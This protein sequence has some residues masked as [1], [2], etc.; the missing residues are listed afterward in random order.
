VARPVALVLRALGLGDLLTGVPALR[1]LRRALPDH[2]LLLVEPFAL[3]PLTRLAVA[4]DEVVA[5]RELDPI[6]SELPPV[7]LAVDLHGRGP[8]SM[9][10][11][12]VHEPGELWSFRHPHVPESEGGPTWTADEHEVARWCRMCR[13]FGV[14]ASE[15][16]LSVAVPPPP[17]H[18]RR[19]VVVHPGASA[20]A[21]EWPPERYAAVCQ[22]LAGAYPIVVTGS[23]SERALAQRVVDAA[24]LGASA[25]LAGR[26]DLVQLAAVVGASTATVSGDT[27]IAHLATAVGA[28]SVTLFGPTPPALW[29]PPADPRHRVLWTGSRGDPHA[30][31]VFHGLLAIG[32]DDVVREVEDLLS[33]RRGRVPTAAAP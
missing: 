31:A 11:L 12:L 21:R 14:P 30:D 6:T 15:S 13:H 4:V 18:L 8:E 28:P 2:R 10:L 5:G 26:L 22:R 17:R 33:A 16:D 7:D 25:N 29:G 19:R 32:V 9:Q 23:R 3:A 24:G 20:V 1:G 27:G